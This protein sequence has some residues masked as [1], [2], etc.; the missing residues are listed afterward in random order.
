V[1]EA[2]RIRLAVE[3]D[4]PAVR[5]LILKAQ[6]NPTGLDWRRFLVAEAEGEIIATGQLKPHRDGSMELAS[7]AIT[8]EWRGQG[9]ARTLIERLIAGHDGVLYLM[10]QS[11]LGSLY[12]KF[13][14]EA[15]DEE[16]MP[17]YFRRV[18][19]LAGLAEALIQRGETLLVMRRDILDS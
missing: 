18:S 19:K 11:S 6:I 16:E 17:K 7:I 14:F 4:F 5:A 10:C 13:G 3:G 12:E 1:A 8:E 9:I 15:I 2:Y